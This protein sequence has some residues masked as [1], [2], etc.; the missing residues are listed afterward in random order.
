V[1]LN[2]LIIKWKP[3]EARSQLR[4]KKIFDRDWQF[5]KQINGLRK[6]YYN[7]PNLAA[8]VSHRIILL[9]KTLTLIIVQKQVKHFC[10]LRSILNSYEISG[11][12]TNELSLWSPKPT[13]QVGKW[14][15]IW[16]QSEM[17]Q[18]IPPRGLESFSRILS[19]NE[20]I[21]LDRAVVISRATRAPVPCAFISQIAG[22]CAEPLG[23][24]NL[25]LPVWLNA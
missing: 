9:K 23:Q 10:R 19:D 6:L 14:D 15:R 8:T 22:R 3:E 7:E 11:S 20:R 24:R 2:S 1:T 4:C 13:S 17:R 5:K 25:Q 18:I 21:L 16:N 12:P